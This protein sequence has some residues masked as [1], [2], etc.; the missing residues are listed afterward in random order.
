MKNN[1]K[2]LNIH[3]KTFRKE[4]QELLKRGFTSWN[5]I[6]KLT[7]SDINDL[8]KQ[9]CGSIRNLNCLNCIATF[10]CDLD[11][12][13]EDAALLIHSGIPSIQSLAN[14][15]PPEVFK[16]ISRLEII[17][18]MPRQTKT[19]LGKVNIWVEKAKN[20]KKKQLIY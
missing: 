19:D 18:G 7:T 9:G 12:L 10:I 11:L 17:L 4:H 8:A 2:V 15:S 16:R 20:W 3:L 5:S 6:T 14:L 13:Q 1:F